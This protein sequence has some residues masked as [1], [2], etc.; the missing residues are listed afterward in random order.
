[1]EWALK[2]RRAVEKYTSVAAPPMDADDE[3]VMGPEF[4][5]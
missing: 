3:T 5:E 2:E 4:P 1:L